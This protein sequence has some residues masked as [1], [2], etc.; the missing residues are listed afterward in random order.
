MSR[1]GLADGLIMVTQYDLPWREDL[2]QG[3]HFYDVSQC[4]EFE[5]AGYKV[6]VIKQI[7]PWCLHDCGKVNGTGYEDNRKIFVQHYRDYLF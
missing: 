2:F 1:F 3:W 6:G 7:S 4:L 5:K